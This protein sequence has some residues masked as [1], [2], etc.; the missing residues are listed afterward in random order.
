[1][2]NHTADI[3]VEAH[4]DGIR[5]H[6]NVITRVVVVEEVGLL[7]ARLGRKLA[8]HHA[9]LE[10][11]QALDRLAYSEDVLPAEGHDAVPFAHVLVVC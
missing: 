11:R 7:R 8:V 9:A 2:E 5:R 4:P 1:V 3:E 10:R 6:E